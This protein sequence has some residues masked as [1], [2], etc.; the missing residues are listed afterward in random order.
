MG[1]LPRGRNGLILMGDLPSK[2]K[3]EWIKCEELA[4]C[5]TVL[6]DLPGNKI[7]ESDF[8]SELQG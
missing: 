6:G 3:R 8:S 4:S 2:K 5:L 1:D 7:L